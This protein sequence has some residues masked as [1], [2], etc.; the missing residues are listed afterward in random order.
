MR[1]PLLLA[2]TLTLAMASVSALAAPITRTP[3]FPRGPWH[4]QTPPGSETLLPVECGCHVELSPAQ[5][6]E[7]ARL[8]Q[9]PAAK[10]TRYDQAHVFQINREILRP[11][12][13]CIPTE[14]PHIPPH[15]PPSPSLGM[16]NQ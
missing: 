11:R 6:K 9:V 16:P 7:Y 14:P 15:I 2:C 3:H 1:L 10:L 4:C 13:G 12:P 8:S 5:Q